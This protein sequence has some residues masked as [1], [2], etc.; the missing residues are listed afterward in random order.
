MNSN[1]YDMGAVVVLTFSMMF[2]SFIFMDN[3][4]LHDYCYNESKLC[5]DDHSND[6][7]KNNNDKGND[8]DDDDDHDFCRCIIRIM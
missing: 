4:F 5:D 8:N 7:D 6:N 1:E 2:S 3:S